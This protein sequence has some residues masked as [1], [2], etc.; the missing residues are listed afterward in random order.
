[1]LEVSGLSV[2]KE[3]AAPGPCHPPPG[4]VPQAVGRGSPGGQAHLPALDGPVSTWA[5]VLREVSRVQR[6][7]SRD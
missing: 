6:S 1:M 7:C 5:T 4:E 3:P 2:E